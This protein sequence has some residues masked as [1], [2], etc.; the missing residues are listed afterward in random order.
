LVIIRRGVALSVGAAGDGSDND[1]FKYI[2]DDKVTLRLVGESLL[3]SSRLSACRIGAFA[4]L[5]FVHLVRGTRII[6]GHVR[7]LRV[8]A[9][10]SPSL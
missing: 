8:S 1:P 4:F 10:R 6:V 3:R 2:Q 5:A 7:T 9:Q